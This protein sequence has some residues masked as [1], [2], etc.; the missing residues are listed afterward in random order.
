[1]S[2]IWSNTK[3]NNGIQLQ[4][5]LINNCRAKDSVTCGSISKDYK[6]LW[7][8]PKTRW[9]ST[10][11]NGM[12]PV[13]R[14]KSRKLKGWWAISKRPWPKTPPWKSSTTFF[15]TPFKSRWKKSLTNCGNR[16]EKLKRNMRSKRRTPPIKMCKK[17]ISSLRTETCKLFQIS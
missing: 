2:K 12:W 8:K 14:N 7:R 16:S 5:C 13:S 3:M 17:S 1:M 10:K 4:G 15:S 6:I 9:R 11:W